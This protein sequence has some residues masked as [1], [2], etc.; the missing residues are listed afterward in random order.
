[1]FRRRSQPM[2]ALCFALGATAIG[3]AVLFVMVPVIGEA[4]KIGLGSL[5]LVVAVGIFAFVVAAPIWGRASDRLGRR[6]IMLWGCSGVIVGQGGFAVILTLA[7]QDYIAPETTLVAMMF[8]RLLH[9]S[10]AAALF[11]IAQAWVADL[12]GESERLSKFG[13]LRLA[14][15][16]GRLVGPPFAAVLT[17]L[18]P[19]APIYALIAFAVIARL[20]MMACREPERSKDGAGQVPAAPPPARSAFRTFP[21]LLSVVVLLA[22]MNGQIQF[23]IGLHA[24]TRLGLNAVQASQFV[25]VLLSVAA[26]AALLIQVFVIKRLNSRVFAAMLLS[27]ALASSAVALVFWGVHWGTFALA[28]VL[29]GMSLAMAFP[30]CAALLAAAQDSSHLG[31]AMGA[32][33]SAQTIGYALGA[34]LG[35]LYEVSPAASFGLSFCAPLIAILLISVSRLRPHIR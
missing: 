4:T 21:L 30:A 23:A 15:T 32:F 12:Y 24:Q 25:G 28:A 20:A 7:D 6:D 1:M 19:L 22:V 33:G 26:V 27:C 2:S 10:A 11:P 13:T 3:Q 31:S 34:G 35:G 29:V 16:L 8:F 18:A 5:S 14:M 9:G 17:L